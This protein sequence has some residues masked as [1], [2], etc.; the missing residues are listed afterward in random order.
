MKVYVVNVETL[1]GDCGIMRCLGGI[2]DTE[3]KAEKYCDELKEK[4][5][6]TNPDFVRDLE[7]HIDAVNLNRGH[8]LTFVGVNNGYLNIDF[9]E[10]E[11]TLGSYAE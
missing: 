9:E 2:F 1:Y 3:E 10:R 6:E 7:Y 11:I 5:K 8:S 4:I